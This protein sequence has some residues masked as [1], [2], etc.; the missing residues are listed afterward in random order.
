M[1]G[2]KLM[3]RSAVNHSISE[4]QDSDEASSKASSSRTVPRKSISE[5]DDETFLHTFQRKGYPVVITE[6][7]TPEPE[8]NLDFLCEQIGDHPFLIRQFG[9]ERYQQNKRQW[10]SIGSGVESTSMSFREYAAAIQSG[11]AHAEDLYLAKVP[12]T[13]TLLAENAQ[14]TSLSTQLPL[15]WPVTDWNLWVGPSGHTTCLHYD[16]FDGVLAQLCG[17]KR[18]V[19][20]PPSQLYN[21]YPFPMLNHLRYG[22]KL[23]S[24]YSQI[25]PD[26]ID[27][28]AFPKA[29]MAQAHCYEVTVNAGE[30]IFIPAGWWHEISTVG[31]GMVCSVNRF[32]H[33]YPWSRSLSSWSKW[34]VHLASVL[35]APHVAWSLLKAMGSKD[36]SLKLGQLIQRI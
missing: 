26:A 15:R 36:K 29:R 13:Q 30:M 2:E 31:S 11:Q 12:V 20:F 25:Y 27:D 5:L 35:A 14:L 17:A 24:G 32:W 19:L 6:A 7:V 23:R 4:H 18:I 9:R 22:A 33:V 1:A 16:P 10:T 34:R 28:E 8:W 21:L 3:Q